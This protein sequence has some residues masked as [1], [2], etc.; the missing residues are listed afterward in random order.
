VS[1]ERILVGTASW[2]DPGFVEFWYP[3]KMR[4]GDRLS[5]YAQHFDMVE[6]NSTF[7]AVPD[8]AMVARWCQSTPRGFI[9]NLKLHQFFSHHS[10]PAK[11]LPPSMQRKLDKTKRVAVTPERQEQLWEM[12]RDPLDILLATGKLG[13]LL[14]QLSP[15]FSPGKHQ[16]KELEQILSLARDYQVAIELRNRNWFEG[17]Q[18]ELTLSFL[19]DRRAIFVNIDG[20]AQNHFTIVPSELDAV[21]NPHVA[22]LRLHGRDAQAYLKGKTVAE[23]FCY[24]YTEAEIEEVAQRSERLARDSKQV[25]VVFNNNARDYAPHAAL[26]LRKAL[27]QIITA[28]ARTAELF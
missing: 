19:R 23:R 24:D 16:L 11:L 9:F 22:Y 17:E 5:W 14:L 1:R 15:A 28:P 18:C 6:V 13:I 8:P 3:A 7:Y 4:A 20:P 27:G 25:H 10:T 26:R 2:S 12:F 21:T